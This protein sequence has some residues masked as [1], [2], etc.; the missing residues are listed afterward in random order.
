MARPE[1]VAQVEAI[2]E[3]LKSA[4]SVILA[5]YQ[6]MT[7]E[8]MTEFRVKCRA[9]DVH[10]RV[11]KNRLAK[12][13]ADQ[14]DVPGLKQ[15][16]KGPL[17]LVMGMSSPVEP[18]KLV[19]DFAKDH[20]KMKLVGGFMEGA[21]MTADEVVALSKIP[22]REE[23]YAKMMGSINSPASGLVGVTNGVAAALTRAIDAVAKKKAA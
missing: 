21:Y 2:A 5:D 10:C 7:V 8:H 3:S 18:A 15:Y 12:I 1:K 13:A 16:L 9:A 20:D 11:V 6:G 14:V 4:Q 17:A 22:S 19:V 23:L